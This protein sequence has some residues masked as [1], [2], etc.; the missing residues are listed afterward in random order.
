MH[1]VEQPLEA[2]GV[3]VEAARSRGAAPGRGSGLPGAREQLAR[4]AGA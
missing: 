1:R 4:A 2:S 3:R